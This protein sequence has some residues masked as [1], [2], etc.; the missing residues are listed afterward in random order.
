VGS[1]EEEDRGFDPSSPLILGLTLAMCPDNGEHQN[2]VFSK[3]FSRK[4]WPETGS[5][6]SNTRSGF[7]Q[8]LQKEI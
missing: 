8:G 1:K 2:G 6:S 5:G 4:D 7:S 3:P